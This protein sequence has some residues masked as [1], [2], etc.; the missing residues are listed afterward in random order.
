M[1]HFGNFLPY[2]AS[3]YHTHQ[4][5]AYM[6]PLWI[7]SAFHICRLLGLVTSPFAEDCL[8]HVRTLALGGAILCLS[9]LVSVWSIVEPVALFLTFG[10][11]YGV[12]SGVM[13]PVITKICQPF[14]DG[15]S[16]WPDA[17][18][19]VSFPAGAFI[20]MIVAFLIVNP[21]NK[22][23]DL[24]NGNKKF[25]SNDR[26]N[27]DVPY[28]FLAL[29]FIAAVPVSLGLGLLYR[30]LG[31]R[32]GKKNYD[33]D[34]SDMEEVVLYA[35]KDEKQFVKKNKKLTGQY[36]AVKDQGQSVPNSDTG[37]VSLEADS[38]KKTFLVTKGREY[39]LDYTQPHETL[40]SEDVTGSE[41]KP[42]FVP[43]NGKDADAHKIGAEER[44]TSVLLTETDSTMP[45]DLAP[46][47][48]IKTKD[49]WSLWLCMLFAGHTQFIQEN[50]YKM[51][52]QTEISNDA[53]LLLAGLLGMV[54]IVVV[55]PLCRVAL[56][57]WGTKIVPASVCA[58][59]AGFMTLM[60][61][62]HE[63]FPPL[64]IVSTAVEFAAV[65]CVNLL[66]TEFPK[67]LFGSCHVTSNTLLLSTANVVVY[68]LDP[69]IA[70]E[71]LATDGW[72]WLIASGSLTAAAA[73]FGF[74]LLLPNVR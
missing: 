17:L 32:D 6:E 20:Y 21:H 47:D 54:A 53:V 10:I 14:L 4:P 24:D 63:F 35:A 52:G 28:Y 9:L 50:L 19:V 43:K 11:L 15:K 5:Q 44:V 34:F 72:D 38:I 49:F 27:S 48:V 29:A 30:N 57:R 41:G 8:G 37:D 31:E 74:I 33:A 67:R 26:L 68:L 56:E 66:Y 55:R 23:P 58:A 42:D 62:F 3:Y 46:S 51:Y 64:Y 7:V 73:L 61:I 2:L 12:G 69:I 60:F 18:L 25:F 22:K 71:A 70:H 16:S 40:T 1:L 59:A 13:T 45:R 39:W 36:G 65:S